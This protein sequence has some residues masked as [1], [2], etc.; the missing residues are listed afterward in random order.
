M[1][2]IGCL[3][4]VSSTGVT[5]MPAKIKLTYGSPIE[6]RRKDCPGLA[7]NLPQ[8][9]FQAPEHHTYICAHGFKDFFINRGG[10]VLRILLK[11]RYFDE[12]G[13]NGPLTDVRTLRRIRIPLRPLTCLYGPSR[14]AE[15]N[16]CR[17]PKTATNNFFPKRC[18][19]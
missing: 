4:S 10:D 11:I 7:Q 15:S 6:T 8:K 13:V 12:D 5:C 18:V 9:P 19:L 14:R 17:L 3:E 1:A 2:M 16:I